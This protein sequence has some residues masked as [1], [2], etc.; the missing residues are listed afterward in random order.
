MVVEGHDALRRPRQ[1]GDDEADPRAKLARMPL[2]L[3]YHPPGFLTALR[4]I[5]EAGV[6]AAHLIRRSTHRA[7]EE[8]ANL[9]LQDVVGRQASHALG[10]EELVNLRVSEGRVTP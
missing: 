4:L 8:V 5:A 3:R 7:L 2:D 9:A 1:V 10:F 6:V